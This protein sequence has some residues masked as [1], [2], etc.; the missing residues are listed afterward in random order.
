[1]GITRF[2]VLWG[3]GAVPLGVVVQQQQSAWIAAVLSQ[4]LVGGR[5]DQRNLPAHTQAAVGT[6][7]FLLKQGQTA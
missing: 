4:G 1:M 7:V 6:P 3:S 5:N 2:A